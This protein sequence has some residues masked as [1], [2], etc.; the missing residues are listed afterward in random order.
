MNETV[1]V[2]RP[3]H[4][5]MFSNA[6]D[7]TLGVHGGLFV[8]A[9]CPVPPNTAAGFPEDFAFDYP[10]P[11]YRLPQWI[12]VKSRKFILISAD[13]LDGLDAERN[14]IEGGHLHEPGWRLVP[15][16][17]RQSDALREALQNG[18]TPASAKDRS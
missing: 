9:A 2:E 10:G 14:R 6:R 12:R 7:A 16:M 3:M 11:I 13:S 18:W 8:Q 1:W 5:E 17:Y 4:V 15:L